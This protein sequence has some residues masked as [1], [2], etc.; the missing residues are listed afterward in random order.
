MPEQV[1]IDAVLP[2][3]GTSDPDFAA[4]SGSPIKALIKFPDKTILEN[5]AGAMHGSSQI[6]RTVIIGSELVRPIAEKLDCFWVEE[7]KSGPENIFKGLDYLNEQPDPPSHILIATTDIP[8]ITTAHVD[9]LLG[10]LSTR[11]DIYVPCVR[12]TDFIALYEGCPATFVK[13]KND[14]FTL[15]GM[16]LYD[17]KVLQRVRPHIERIFNQRK[18]L[19]GMAKLVGPVFAFKLL[20]RMLVIQ[21]VENKVG[22]VL[23][24]QGSAVL[25]CPAELAFDVDDAEDYSYGMQWVKDHPRT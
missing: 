4:V 7:G 8:F 2:A 1:L 6:R 15:G 5:V 3:G 16:F 14:S 20:T 21:D 18:S 9:W 25:D 24:C 23:Q 17:A 12:E 13:M 22:A 11:K 19:L 10:H